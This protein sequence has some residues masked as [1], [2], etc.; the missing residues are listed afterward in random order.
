MMHFLKKIKEL[1]FTFC[2][3]YDTIDL[4]IK[5]HIKMNHISH[6]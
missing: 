3:W 6:N 2:S 5:T 4:R 1:M